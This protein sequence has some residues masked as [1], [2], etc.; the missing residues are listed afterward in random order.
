M[1]FCPVTFSRPRFC[2]ARSAVGA[3][4]DDVDSVH[5]GV[6]P[7]E[8][9]NGLRD[10]AAGHHALAQPGLV[11]DEKPI[12]GLIIQVETVEDMFHRPALKVPEP[13]QCGLASNP[14][15]FPQSNAS[16]AAV[17]RA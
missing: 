6:R 7:V 2:L 1:S 4:V 9:L 12:R 8:Q 3:D 5:T 11:R 13:V 16:V 10:D 17:H 14:M 15:E